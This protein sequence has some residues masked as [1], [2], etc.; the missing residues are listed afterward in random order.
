M[1]KLKSKQLKITAFVLVVGLIVYILAALLPYVGK[2]YVSE[3]TKQAFSM[4]QFYGTNEIPERVMLVEEPQEAF[5]HRM[6]LIAQAQE[7]IILTTFAIHGGTTTDMIIGALLDSADRGVDVTILQDGLVGKMPKNYLEVLSSHENI[8][9]YFFNSFDLLRPHY[10]NSG[11]HDKYL[12]IDNTFMLLGGRNI[13]DKYYNPEGFDGTVS[14]DREVLVYNTNP[15]FQGSIFD[16]RNY[17]DQKINS[18]R[19]SRQTPNKKSNDKWE[20]QR[21]YYLYSYMAYLKGVRV[22]HF[23]YEAH[24]IG[25]NGITLIFDTF[26]TTK[27]E[28]IVAY[29]LLMLTK[30]S[31][32]IIA[33]SPYVVLT[34][35]NYKL[36]AEAVDDKNFILSTNSLASTP[37][38][39]A[40]SAYYTSRYN[41]LKTGIEIYEYQSFESSL[42]GK[43]YLFDG[44][45]T[46]IG[47][48]NKNERS[49][50]S[51]TES[52]L[53]IDSEEFHDIT[54]DA[55]NHQASQSL[56]VSD[57][58]K[59]EF[60]SDVEVLNVSFGRKVLYVIAGYLLRVFRFLF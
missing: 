32:V 46:A 49:I 43:S 21:D 44:R 47:S 10:L 52:M 24:T 19:V 4:E 37:N 15:D 56:R 39:P 33:Q 25:V 26:D 20:D 22:S 9:I 12:I 27:K 60:N 59:Y 18:D 48:F 55:I 54:L 3:E 5:F 1:A 17:F 50:R 14:L 30:N 16:T 41:L 28:S 40:F 35:Q 58:N 42:H 36:F 11:L 8:N 13:G 29:N 38:L 57:D 53:I 2:V 23:D 31:E 45:L 34:N 51:D 7:E 6:N